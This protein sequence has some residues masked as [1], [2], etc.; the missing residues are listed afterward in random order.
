[1]Y[2][3]TV[4]PGAIQIMADGHPFLKAPDAHVFVSPA[5]AGFVTRIIGPDRTHF[6]DIGGKKV[7]GSE[8]QMID[9]VVF[10]A[11]GRHWAAKLQTP[12]NSQVVMADGKKG[13][14]YQSVSELGFGGD[15]RVLY[16]AMNA[17]KSFLV[18]GDQESDAWQLIA[19]V[20]TTAQGSILWAT[21]GSR[22]GFIGINNGNM[23]AVVDGK[24]IPRRG[25][26]D[27][28]MSPDGSR[29]AFAFQGGL[30]V[31]GVDDAS[32]VPAAFARVP[33]GP[34][35]EQPGKF[36]FSPDSKHIAW[37]GQVPALNAW[38]LHIDG[39]FFPVWSNGA[40][41]PTFTPDSRHLFWVDHAQN[42]NKFV[43]YLDGKEVTRFEWNSLAINRANWWDM[44]ADGVLT[45]VVP[46][47]GSLK[48]IR[49]TPGS[50]TSVETLLAAA[51]RR[52]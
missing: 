42:E 44:G 43:V 23:A 29:F 5:G 22:V 25:V 50:D 19:P 12:A 30:N 36:V 18:V 51:K 32:A 16:H 47:G 2:A 7:V 40:V 38:G 4:P 35:T 3:K 39:K 52:P 20:R 14:E 41:A 21:A 15:G 27:L 33:H 1:M 17:G 9:S 34:A 13:Q 49:V 11:D 45:L 28:D 8:A 46:D 37:F 6:L 31:D 10:N 48:R 26:E 24:A